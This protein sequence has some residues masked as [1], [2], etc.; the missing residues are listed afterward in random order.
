MFFNLMVQKVNVFP[1]T[2]NEYSIPAFSHY[3]VT[4]KTL[5]GNAQLISKSEI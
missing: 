2:A 5:Y 4:I 3:A 1:M